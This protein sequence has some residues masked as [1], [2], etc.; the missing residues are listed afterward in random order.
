MFFEKY[1]SPDA[2]DG[3]NG[4]DPTQTQ[5][6]GGDPTLNN[7]GNG[8]SEQ[9]LETLKDILG[10]DFDFDSLSD[11]DKAT[12]QQMKGLEKLKQLYVEK[13]KN[14]QQKPP[15]QTKEEQSALFK[16]GYSDGQAKALRELAQ[17]LGVEKVTEKMLMEWKNNNEAWREVQNKDKTEDQIKFEELQL[18]YE[19]TMGSKIELEKRIEEHERYIFHTGM[20]TALE[21]AAAKHGAT[22]PDRVAILLQETLSVDQK[23]FDEKLKEGE[24]TL[25]IMRK[26]TGEIIDLDKFMEEYKKNKDNQDLFESFVS[27][28]G[29]G[30]P[31]QGSKV[32]SQQKSAQELIREG[33][34]QHY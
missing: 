34:K 30:S 4:G 2:I 25:P 18:S 16:K 1:L 13:Q 33:M 31:N 32:G 28:S 5:Q 29:S 24:Y 20:R 23:L 19:E 3:G 15:K 8:N 21:N 22:R 14:N 26:D 9:S 6:I 10:E 27:K 7:N 11:E 17:K 12:F